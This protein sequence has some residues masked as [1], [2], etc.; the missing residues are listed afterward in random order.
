MKRK[1]RLFAALAALA[2]LLIC[3]AAFFLSFRRPYSDIV[4]ESGISPA[5]VYAVMKAESGFREDAVSEAGAVGLMQLMPA[6]AEFIC[7]RDGAEFYPDRLTDG[8]YNVTLGCRYLAYLLERFCV[9]QT[10]V[11]AYNAGEGTVENWLLDDS[12]SAD[13]KSLSTIP[14]PETAEYV[15]KVENFRKI[16]GIFYH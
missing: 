16:Y 12:L 7:R 5:L 4:E 11:A 14:F 13:G 2:A 9:L 15:K 1:S 8:A 3:I 10:A 6:T